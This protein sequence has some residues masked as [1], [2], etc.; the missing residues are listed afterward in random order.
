MSSSVTPPPLR[1]SQNITGFRRLTRRGVSGGNSTRISPS[2]VDPAEP[3]VRACAETTSI[4]LSACRQQTT[5]L[6][7]GSWDC[8]RQGGLG[9]INITQRESGDPTVVQNYRRRYGWWSTP[10]GPSSLIRLSYQISQRG[11]RRHLPIL[12]IPLRTSNRRGF[13]PEPD[14]FEVPLLSWFPG[15]F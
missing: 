5:H 4:H 15:Q 6:L 9:P 2:E 12:K 14:A 8:P 11:K 13:V 3:G 10:S 7:N 1:E